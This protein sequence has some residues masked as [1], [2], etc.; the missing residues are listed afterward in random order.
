MAPPPPISHILNL[1]VNLIEGAALSASLLC[2][3]HCLAL[4]LLL[5]VLP[6]VIGLFAQSAAFHYAALALV[7]P[8]AVTAFWIGYRRHHAVGPFAL[9]LTGVFLLAFA[10]LPGC[11]ESAELWLTTAGSLLLITGHTINWR[12]RAHSI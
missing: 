11:S 10:L 3:G 8:S 12:L 5:L 6:G 7:V 4:P 9:G 1:P 2:L